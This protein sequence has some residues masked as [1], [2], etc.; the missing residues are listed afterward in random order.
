[1]SQSNHILLF[2]DGYLEITVKSLWGLKLKDVFIL[3]SL[4]N[5]LQ[6][7]YLGVSRRESHESEK[8]SY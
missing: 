7:N 6:K 5:P 1:M 3:L 8:V 2:S 4:E